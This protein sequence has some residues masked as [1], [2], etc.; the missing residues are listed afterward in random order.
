MD[1]QVPDIK[2]PGYQGPERRTGWFD[3][4]NCPQ[5]GRNDQRIQTLEAEVPRIKAKTE[6]CR[7]KMEA[8]LDGLESKH[9][10]DVAVLRER[11]DSK[12]LALWKEID[13]MKERSTHSHDG[14]NRRIGEKVPIKH[15]I[16]AVTVVVAIFVWLTNVNNSANKRIAEAMTN[17]S[18]KLEEKIDK[19]TSEVTTMKAVAEARKDNGDVSQALIMEISRMSDSMVRAVERMEALSQ[20]PKQEKD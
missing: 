18:A 14:L 9:E 19:L 1:D 15:A 10:A 12:D 3:C 7:T 5:H 4:N 16:A 13:L 11:I 20:P 17:N 8:E 6:E 2:A